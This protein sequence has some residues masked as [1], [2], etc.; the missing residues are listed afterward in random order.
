MTSTP[1]KEKRKKKKE[2][3]KAH[4]PKST[5]LSVSCSKMNQIIT[6]PFSTITSPCVLGCASSKPCSGSLYTVQPQ[7]PSPCSSWTP[8]PPPPP[9]QPWVPL[10]SLLSSPPRHH[11]QRTWSQSSQL[12]N[13]KYMNLFLRSEPQKVKQKKW[14]SQQKL[15]RQEMWGFPIKT[16]KEYIPCINM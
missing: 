7:P 14:Q 12:I 8:P 9:P 3:K 10:C 4:V 13:K 15:L 16:G 6:T 11:N 2:E 5:K 1:K